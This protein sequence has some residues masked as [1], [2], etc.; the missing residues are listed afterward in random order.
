VQ[1]A[2]WGAN[3]T[4]EADTL[5]RKSHYLR[6]AGRSTNISLNTAFVV[7]SVL[8]TKI[9]IIDKLSDS[10]KLLNL[11]PGQNI[12]KHK[13]ILADSSKVFSKITKVLVSDPYSLKSS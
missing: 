4:H 13:A 5:G 7:L 2:N 6:T 1:L 10:L 12:P 11:R 8:P 9:I 3:N